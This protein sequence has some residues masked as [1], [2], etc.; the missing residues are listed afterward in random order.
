MD[1]WRF[2]PGVFNPFP[3]QLD[4][5]TDLDKLQVDY[6]IAEMDAPRRSGAWMVNGAQFWM[7][8]L[9]VESSRDEATG[10]Q[11]G[12]RR[13]VLSLPRVHER[14]AYVDIH[15]V[16]LTFKR[17]PRSLADIWQRIRRGI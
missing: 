12:S 17:P 6:V 2:R 15:K 11:E 5:R 14:D 13:F 9:E 1:A 3:V 7:P 10:S 16:E 8:G 4:D